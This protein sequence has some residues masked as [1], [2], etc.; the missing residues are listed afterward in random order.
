MTNIELNENQ[1]EFLQEFNDFQ[2]EGR[3]P[4]YK[5]E[6]NKIC[7]YSFTNK[8]LINVIE[9]KECLIKQL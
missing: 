4:D 1:I 7:D 2:L 9:I 5:F 8:I 3:Y 6:I